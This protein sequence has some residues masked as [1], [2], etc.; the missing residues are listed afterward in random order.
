MYSDGKYVLSSPSR[1]EKKDW[2]ASAFIVGTSGSIMLADE[3]VQERVQAKRNST[4]DRIT[5]I[6]EPFGLEGAILA[7]GGLYLA[8]CIKK[9]TTFKKVTLLC[10]ES[11]L[12]SGVIVGALK[13]LIGRA[14]PDTDE[15]VSSYSPF[16]IYASHWSLPSGHTSTA[17]AI[18][19]CLA[20]ESENTLVK[21]ASYGMAIIIGVSR[22]HDDKHWASDVFL[23]STI[24]I[25]VGKTVSKL[26]KKHY[27]RR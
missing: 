11:A 8:G 22:I 15:G 13:I 21:V 2:L 7:L 18:A 12:I 25:G 6:I 20:S 1:W 3:K 14:R 5:N 10:G 27:T 16:S 17:F 23:A 4:S 24:G 9:D 26:H 19:S